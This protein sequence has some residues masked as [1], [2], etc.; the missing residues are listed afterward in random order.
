[1]QEQFDE[2]MGELTSQK[3]TTAYKNTYAL[4][5]MAY[6]QCKRKYVVTSWFPKI[7]KLDAQYGGSVLANIIMKASQEEY[8]RMNMRSP[9]TLK[10]YAPAIVRKY[11]LDKNFKLK[12]NV[13]ENQ[14]VWLKKQYNY[15]IY[16]RDV[17]DGWYNEENNYMFSICMSN[18]IRWCDLYFSRA[19]INPSMDK[20]QLRKQQIVKLT[21]IVLGAFKDTYSIQYRQPRFLASYNFW[22]L[23]LPQH[24]SG[25]P[26]KV[27]SAYSN[28]NFE[29]N[30]N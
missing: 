17:R 11:K 26:T 7:A 2:L 24:L 23:L 16:G 18:I 6:K 29:Y 1:M 15:K 12:E 14:L 19:T 27:W 9:D 10:R 22:H 30:Q 20:D 3:D 21:D 25:M 5:E 8:Y 13:T 28:C 4:W